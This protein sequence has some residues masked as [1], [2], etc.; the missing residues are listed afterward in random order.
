[1]SESKEVN[2]RQD[3]DDV[4]TNCEAASPNIKDSKISKEEPEDTK[5]LFKVADDIPAGVWLA[6]LVTGGERLA[7]YGAT[8]PF[9]NYLQNGKHSA[10]PG[11][12][13]VH[14]D[15][16]TLIMTAFFAVSYFTPTLGAV[17]ADAWLGRYFTILYSAIAMLAGS[18]VLLVTALPSSIRAPHTSAAG[19]IVTMVLYAFG[20]GFLRACISPFVADQYTKHTP[21]IKTR[22]NGERCITDREVTVQYIYNIYNW[23]IN[24]AGLGALGAT[25]LERY[26]G[27]WAA[28][29]LPLIGISVSSL[30]LILFSTRFV[31]VPPAGTALVKTFQSLKAAARSNFKMDNAKPEA[32]LR[33]KNRTVPWDDKFID[34]LKLALL[35]CRIFLVFP[36]H[37]LA[38]NQTFNNLI[39]QAGQMVNYGVPNDAIKSINPLSS[40]LIYPC[41]QKGLYPYLRQKGIPFRP[42]ARITV[43]FLILTVSMSVAAGVQKAIYVKP[44]CYDHPRECAASDHGRIPNQINMFIQIPIYVLGGMAEMFCLPASQEIAYN[45]SPGSMRSIVSAVS[46]GM[47]GIGSLIAMAFTPLAHNPNQ[48]IMY[49]VLAGIMAAAT[50]VFWIVFRGIDKK[51]LE[52][53]K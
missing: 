12:L 47:A 49:S 4:D 22:K 3:H 9:Q 45:Q 19:L 13:G 31:R 17:I 33:L 5:G 1:M 16:A 11:A 43:G 28:Y 26:V 36:F 52:I 15:T 29:M 30:I 39:S 44:P 51:D 50:I 42:V 27:F 18:I 6:C 8:G 46:I 48:V 41:I 10:L 20:S 38:L 2:T 37:W 25:V 32:Q 23:V 21:T 14:Q 40:I 7:W 35:A 53:L 24:I 34:E